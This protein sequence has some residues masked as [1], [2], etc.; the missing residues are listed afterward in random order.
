M[1]EQVINA[2]QNPE[3]A[4]QLIDKALKEPE[5]V[6]EPAKLTVPTNIEVELPGGLVTFSGELTQT[7]EVRELTGK[8]E[9]FIA[10]TTNQ[11][12]IYSAVLQRG[13]VSL[14]ETSATSEALGN[15]LLGD[16]DALMLG[17]YRATYGD[18]AKL[19]GF[20][21]CGNTEEVELDLLKD[22]ETK[23]LIDPVEDRTFEVV[24]RSKTFLVT[25]PTGVTEAKI[26]E[27]TGTISEKVSILLEQTVLTIDGQRVVSRAQVQNLGMADRDKLVEE[28]SNRSPGPKFKDITMECPDC[29][30]ELVVPVS[31]GALFRF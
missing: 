23:P 2:A 7:A 3:L 9:E 6:I 4:K 15:L 13:V 5:I 22:I 14:G 1:T 17:I 31:I 10:K 29:G 11:N 20:C 27:S 30:G 21:N 24:G 19:L 16:R 25:L 26:V 18:T 8:D 28:I 12:K